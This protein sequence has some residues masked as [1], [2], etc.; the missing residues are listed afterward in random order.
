M[1]ALF[2]WNNLSKDFLI[3]SLLKNKQFGDITYDFSVKKGF[4]ISS[5]EDWRLH[6]NN[7]KKV[8]NIYILV[9]LGWENDIFSGYKIGLEILKSWKGQKPPTLQFISMLPRQ[10]LFDHVSGKEQYLVKVF[11]H[12]NLLDITNKKFITSRTEIDE[13]NFYKNYALTGAGILD[14]FSHRLEMIVLLKEK[15]TELTSLIKQIE[16][17]FSLVGKEVMDHVSFFNASHVDLNKFTKKLRELINE[18]KSV[19]KPHKSDKINISGNLNVMILEDNEQHLEILKVSL[20]RYF[21]KDKIQCFSNGIQAIEAYE[22]NPNDYNLVF[23]DLE[24]LEGNF[25]QPIQGLQVLKKIRNKGM[26]AFTIITGLGR[27]GVQE[28]LQVPVKKIISKKQLYQYD[29]DKEVDTILLRMIKEYDIIERKLFVNFGPQKSYFNWEGFRTVLSEYYLEK[30]YRENVWTEAK[31]VLYLFR[32]LRLTK[33]DWPNNSKELISPKQRVVTKYTEF[34]ETKFSTLLGHR[35]IVIYLASLNNFTFYCDNEHYPDYAKTLSDNDI[36]L[37]KGYLDRICF[38]YNKKSDN[39]D[40]VII[41][42]IHKENMFSQELI[43][44]KELEEEKNVSYGEI[45]LENNSPDLFEVFSEYLDLEEAQCKLLNVPSKV[46]AWTI[47]D[48]ISVVSAI[49]DD[50]ISNKKKSVWYHTVESLLDSP[51]FNSAVELELESFIPHITSQIGVLH[52]ILD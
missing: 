23:I 36:N 6:K 13:W 39:T 51:S 7:I 45:Y 31:H 15:K 11:K 47:L 12:S 2:I 26:S 27:K 9:E 46:S 16:N 41:Y 33:K 4:L 28:L 44:I 1:K 18:R 3:K 21:T 20:S 24:L 14:D 38:K 22:K 19:Y 30:E 52:Q 10:F 8:Q 40:N 34:A 42:T 37:N 32:E 50:V 17:Q 48:T 35:L 43:F 25:Y 5:S 29:T 49:F